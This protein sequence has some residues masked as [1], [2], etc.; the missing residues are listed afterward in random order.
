MMKSRYPLACFLLATT[1][2]IEPALAQDA[3]DTA[4]DSALGEAIVVTAR[5]REESLQETPISITAFSGRGLEARGIQ[6]TEG[7]AQITPNLTLQN[8][9]A[10]SGASNS[11]TIYIRGV[12]QQD[13]VP[14]VEPGVGVYVDGVYVARSI[15]SI[16]DL[17][18]F[19]RIEVLR[20]PQ[21]TLFGRNTIGGAISVTTKAP[22]QEF[23]ASGS[24]TY[25][26][27]DLF[28]LKGS[29]NLPLG[30][31]AALR[32]SVGWFNQDG[33]VTRTFDGKKLGDSDRLAGRVALRLEPVDGWT[34]DLAF[35]GTTARENGPAISLIGINYGRTI[36]PATPPF[37]DISNIIANVMSGG[38]MV[39]CATA[40][41]PINLAVAG[42]YD[43]RYVLGPDTN[44]GTAPSYS[45]SDVWGL[46]LT[47]SFEL[48]DSLDLKSI[49]AYRHLS[50]S[51]ARDG[52]GSP[53]VIAQ[54]YDRL[55][56]KQFSQ[57]IQLLGKNFDER[58]NWILGAYYFKESGINTNRLLFTISEFQSGG[59]FKNESLAFF[60]QGTLKIG[61]RFSL[62]A[63]LRYTED[64]KSFHPDQFIIENRAAFLGA[65]FDSP[66]FAEGTRVLPDVNAKVKFSEITPMVNLSYDVA[67]GLMTYATWSRGFKSGGFSQRVFPPIIPGVTTPITDPVAAIPSFSPEKVDAYELGVKFQTPDRALTLNASAF[68]TDYKDMQVQVFTSVAP[69]FQN[70]ASASIKGFELEMQARPLAGL[71][72]EGTA[73]LTDASYDSIDETTTFIDPENAF[74]R[75]SKWTLSAA[76]TYEHELAGGSTLRP[77]V[78]WSWRSRFY[79]NTFNTPEIAQS[80]YHLVNASLGWTSADERFGLQAG[81]KNIADKRYLVSGITVD[82]IQAFEGVYNRGR[83]WS[84]TA[85]VRY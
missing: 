66:I 34:A 38:G 47:N 16:L 80:G 77:R 43:N 39:P 4:S 75:V 11:A 68:Y 53:A 70:A 64:E 52:D 14:T 6:T 31:R 17:V 28:V 50:G 8:N 18:D 40:A 79:N 82:A 29:L 30:P 56:Q 20:G 12:G 62:T 51:F 44:A 81:V 60:G 54:F 27:D 32:A 69:V 10:F 55:K 42:C 84:L 23:E 65:P 33:Y 22:G 1:A 15:G 36:D 58:L 13:F 7:I 76:L 26:T 21:G 41:A 61:E 24:A 46:S 9:P 48:S 73:G 35:D 49:T 78:D 25:G 72:I 74:E 45:R 63:G 2:V 37:A 59:D 67:D 5:K 19:E 57:E 3:P 71:T 83:E 85:S